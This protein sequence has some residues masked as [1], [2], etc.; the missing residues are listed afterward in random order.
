MDEWTGEN[1]DGTH[2]SAGADWACGDV[3]TT[4][5]ECAGGETI[6]LNHDTTL[7]RPRSNMRHVQGTGGLFV[8]DRDAVYV[9]GRSPDHEWEAYE[10]Y[11]EEFEHPLWERY[12]ERGVVAGHGGSDYLGLR[13]FVT[14]LDR[15]LPVPVDAYD[16]AA[17]M[18]LAPLSEQSIATGGEPVPVPDFTDGAWMHRDPAWGLYDDVPADWLDSTT[19]L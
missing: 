6:L 7:P 5:I 15:D 3:V 11:R 10:E 2:P 9:E 17:W 14:C 19:V 4:T 13:T 18:A 16:A 8:E 1:L 12:L